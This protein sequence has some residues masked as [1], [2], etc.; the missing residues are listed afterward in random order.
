MIP[1]F[2]S[3]K[4]R[5]ILI[6]ITSHV[7][8][9]DLLTFMQVI[10]YTIV[11]ELHLFFFLKARMSMVVSAIPGP[12]LAWVD[13]GLLKETVGQLSA[14]YWHWLGRKSFPSRQNNNPQSEEEPSV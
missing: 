3:K 14:P 12:L 2:Y 10:K 6:S 1:W 11:K 8:K 4:P 13:N 9:F 5:S 7:L